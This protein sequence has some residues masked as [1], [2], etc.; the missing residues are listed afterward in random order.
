M[1]YHAESSLGGLY[2]LFLLKQIDLMFEMST[3]IHLI[4]TI[5]RKYLNSHEN[6]ILSNFIILKNTLSKQLVHMGEDCMVF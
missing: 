4:K 5:K 6:R 2:Y 3:E 1:T